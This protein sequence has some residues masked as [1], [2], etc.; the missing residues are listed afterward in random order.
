MRYFMGKTCDQYS[1]LHNSVNTL[2]KSRQFSYVSTFC[3][4]YE[5]KWIFTAENVSTFSSKGLFL[6]FLLNVETSL[7]EVR[8]GLEDQFEEDQNREPSPG[9]N[10]GENDI[11]TVITS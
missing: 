4:K 7:K 11:S 9:V 10:N 1:T 3:R 8:P 6:I 2:S 5:K